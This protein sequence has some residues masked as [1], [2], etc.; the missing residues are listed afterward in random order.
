MTLTDLGISVR[1]AQ[2]LATAGIGDVRTLVTKSGDDI[3]GIEGVGA[4]ALE[5]I[6]HSLSEYDLKLTS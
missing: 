2:K 6:E 5:E 1:R 3:L 4:K